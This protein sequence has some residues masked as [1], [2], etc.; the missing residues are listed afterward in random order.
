MGVERPSDWHSCYFD[1]ESPLLPPLSSMVQDT[2]QSPFNSGVAGAQK[3]ELAFEIPGWCLVVVL[4][5]VTGHSLVFFV[6]VFLLLQ[7]P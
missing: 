3:C 1:L 2:V 4:G 7:R 5:N 6:V